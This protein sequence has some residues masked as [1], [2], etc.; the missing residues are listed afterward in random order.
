MLVTIPQLKQLGKNC[1]KCA[2]KAQWLDKFDENA[3]AYC[4]DHF[5]YWDDVTNEMN[6]CKAALRNQAIILCLLLLS[7][8][9]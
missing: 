2:K 9:F 1:T 4:D 5:P 3:P 8:S 6:Q 7:R